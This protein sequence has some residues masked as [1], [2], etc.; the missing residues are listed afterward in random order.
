MNIA[1]LERELVEKK[2]YARNLLERTMI[3][4]ANEVGED[5][6]RLMTASERRMVEAATA[7]A[8]AVQTQID[9]ARG[10]ARMT[11]A[12]ASLTGDMTMPSAGSNVRW[13]GRSIG[14]QF[15]GNEEYRRFIQSGGHRRSGS[16]TSPAIEAIGSRQM[17][18]A[19][20]TT[21]PAS[22]GALVIPDTRPGV[23]MLPQP[24]PVVAD[25]IAPGTTNSNVVQYMK[26]VTFANAAAAVAQGAVKPESSLTF[27]TATSPVQKLAHW[28]PVTEEM[29]ED[30]SQTRSM[31]D[32]QLRLGLDLEEDDQLLNGDGVSPNIL[33]IRNLPGKTADY[34]RG[35]GENNMDAIGQQIVNIATTVL[36]IPDAIVMAPLNV[37]PMKKMKSTTGEYLAGSPFSASA[38]DVRY[39]WGLPLVQSPRLEAG[40]AL[41]GGFR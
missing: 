6:P 2:R 10:D 25:V 5:G 18:A 1:E 41:V 39:L 13:D 17:Y 16:W 3:Q 4:C 22:G 38:L 37:W 32:A 14:E 34:V 29:L 26:Q 8:R 24:P 40:V 33:G 35:A 30:F 19:T 15:A 31:V 9:R 28:L 21:E 20:L 11:D 12:I 7:E 27:E 23:V 36:V